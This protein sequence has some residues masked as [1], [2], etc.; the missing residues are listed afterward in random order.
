MELDPSIEVYTKRDELAA[1]SETV[2]DE[3]TFF[4]F[5]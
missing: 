2:C 4:V 1:S 3:F 5:A